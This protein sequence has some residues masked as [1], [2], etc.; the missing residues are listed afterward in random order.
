MRERGRLLPRRD[1]P[2]NGGRRVVIEMVH[3]CAT[4]NRHNPI[5]SKP[6]GPIPVIKSNASRYEEFDLFFGIGSSL[7][8]HPIHGVQVGA[9]ARLDYIGTGPFTGNEPAASEVTLSN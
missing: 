9:G 4:R 1:S 3:F 8:Q 6:A 5:P 2:L 7:M